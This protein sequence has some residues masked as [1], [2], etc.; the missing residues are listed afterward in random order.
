MLYVTSQTTLSIA[1]W[2]YKPT[3][4]FSACFV[5]TR[6]LTG[7]LPGRLP[8]QRLLQVKHA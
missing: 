5:P 6:T 8:I 3:Q 7:K 4:V 1:D 2:P